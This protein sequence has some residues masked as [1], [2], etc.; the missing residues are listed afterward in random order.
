LLHI[1]PYKSQSS[2]AYMFS[3]KLVPIP[4]PNLCLCDSQSQ[5]TKT[6]CE[7]A[8]NSEMTMNIGIGRLY[9]KTSYAYEVITTSISSTSFNLSSNLYKSSKAL[10]G[11]LGRH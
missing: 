3:D 4:L 10:F 9:H 5:V 8:S 2:S 6:R 1:S 7:G 11:L